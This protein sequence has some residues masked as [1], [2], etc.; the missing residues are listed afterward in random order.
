MDVD[1]EQVEP[2]SEA[3]ASSNTHLVSSHVHQKVGGGSS[4][5][6]RLQ[7]RL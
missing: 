2:P 1:R 6:G 4:I 7:K 5:E 3:S